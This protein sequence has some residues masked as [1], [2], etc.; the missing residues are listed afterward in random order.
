LYFWGR[1]ILGTTAA[2]GAVFLFALDPTILGHSFLVTT[3]VGVAAFT[4][5]FLFTLWEYLQAPNWRRLAVC[6][7]AMGAMLCAKF[8]AVLLLPVAAV[9]VIASYVWR[10]PNMERKPFAQAGRNDPCPCGSGKKFKACHGAAGKASVVAVAADSP[11]RTGAMFLAICG[12]AYVTVQA[13]YFFPSNPLVYLDGV[14]RVNADHLSGY[15]TMMAGQMSHRFLSYFAVAYLLKEPLPGIVLAA[16]GLAALVRARSVP[17]LAK[18]FLLLP[19]AVLFLGATLWAENIGIR[20]VIPVLPFAHLLG[21][22]GL[23]TLLGA[24][25]RWARPLAIALCVWAVLAAAGIY[26]DHLSYFNESACLLSSPGKIGVDGGSKCGTAWL[27]ESNVD[28]GQGLKQLKTWLDEHA[29]GRTIRLASPYVV[30]PE[31]YGIH[32]VAADMRE[33]EGTPVSGMYA[34]SAHLV[35]RV[36]AQPGASDWL[37]RTAPAAVVGH[38]FYI[39]EIPGGR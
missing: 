26:P 37:R 6:G 5:L 34:V 29:A 11:L 8:S 3:D 12:V 35:A 36:P 21:G 17:R 4:V 33:L 20:Y 9:L 32:S 2:V 14:R 16:I 38:S 25:A 27:D 30:T 31:A 1:Q 39:Y 24:A 23:A 28:W 18:L 15:L 10:G 22:F 19:P 13:I 7:V